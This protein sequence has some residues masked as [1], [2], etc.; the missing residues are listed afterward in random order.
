M[1][2]KREAENLLDGVSRKDPVEHTGAYPTEDRARV[3]EMK[4]EGGKEVV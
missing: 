2:V 1:R 3:V 4:G